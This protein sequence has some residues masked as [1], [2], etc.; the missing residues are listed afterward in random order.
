MLE[1]QHDRFSVNYACVWI[2][3]KDRQ[4]CEERFAKE[5]G[6]LNTDILRLP[7]GRRV[8]FTKLIDRQHTISIKVYRYSPAVVEDPFLSTALGC[9]LF[10]LLVDLGSRTLDFSSTCK[11]SVN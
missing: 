6:K 3:I 2:I 8:T 1:Y 5:T 4:E 7:F 11:G 9:L 10:L